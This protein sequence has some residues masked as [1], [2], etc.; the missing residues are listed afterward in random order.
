MTGYT[1]LLGFFSESR[2]LQGLSRYGGT[3]CPTNLYVESIVAEFVFMEGLP[4]L[5]WSIRETGN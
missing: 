3:I 2:E 4:G 5:P 1:V